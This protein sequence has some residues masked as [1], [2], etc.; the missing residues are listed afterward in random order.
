[1]PYYSLNPHDD[2]VLGPGAV[3]A[4]PYEASRSDAV[5]PVAGDQRLLAV[6]LGY[7]TAQGEGRGYVRYQDDRGFGP[8]LGYSLLAFHEVQARS[9][10]V[11][12]F[13]TG[14]YEGHTAGV[15]SLHYRMNAHDTAA[16]SLIGERIW[17]MAAR[18]DLRPT[19]KDRVNSLQL[20]YRHDTRP[21]EEWG[22]PRH[23]AH[24][25]ASARQAVRVFGGTRAYFSSHATWMRYHPVGES[26]AWAWRLHG[27]VTQGNLPEQRRIWLAGEGVRGYEFVSNQGNPAFV[28]NAEIR[29]P[30]VPRE[31]IP[32]GMLGTV[33][34]IQAAAFADAGTVRRPGDSW[35]LR[36]A[37]GL[38]MRVP[39]IALNRVPLVLR[40]DVAQGFGR[41]GRLNSHLFLTA[42]ELF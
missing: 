14:F 37:V 9:D 2:V 34:R 3:F 8:R 31:N 17:E 36:G 12:L 10:L 26:G 20:A 25:R 40:A 33:Q 32:F 30:L 42:P 5:L 7:S 27:A 16:L 6:G 19:V 13:Q 23:G 11:P 39:V 1:M 28:G 24:V 4:H 18:T 35:V 15:G 21:A 41:G 38:G 22:N 29:L